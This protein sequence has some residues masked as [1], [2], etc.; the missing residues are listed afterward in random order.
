[1]GDGRIHRTDDNYSYGS[2]RRPPS[3]SEDLPDRPLG[4]ESP[5]GRKRLLCDQR[6]DSEIVLGQPVRR[7]ISPQMVQMC[8]PRPD[9]ST[10]R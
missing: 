2:I 6:G 3:Q 5:L 9:D 10:T 4:L 1:M 7:L 8:L